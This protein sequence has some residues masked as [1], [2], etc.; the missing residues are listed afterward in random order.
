MKIYKKLLYTMCMV[1]SIVLTGCDDFLTPDNKSSVTDTDYF[2]TA[3]GFQSLV[4]DAYAQLIDIY[5]S[6]DVPVYFNS[7]TDLYHDGRNDIDAALHRWSNFTPEHGKVKTF[8]TDCYDGIRSCL[9]IQYYA[10]AANVS[11]DVK[12]KAIDEGRFI[13]ALFYYLLV[14]NYGEIGRAS[15]RERV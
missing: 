9:S 12:Q 1:C 7:G 15:C 2:S 14:N 11:D 6:T 8:Y 13:Q 3:S 4:Y 10:S 5:N